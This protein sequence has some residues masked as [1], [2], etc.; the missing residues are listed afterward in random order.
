MNENERVYLVVL[1]QIIVSQDIAAIISDF[2]PGARVIFAADMTDAA[3]RA[4]GCVAMAFVDASLWS[5]QLATGVFAKTMIVLI[6]DSIVAGEIPNCC[7]LD[8]PFTTEHIL[9]LLERNTLA[10]T[11]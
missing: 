9:A 5:E 11:L 8:L 2:D 4:D 1:R 7:R 3:T 10:Q 6:G